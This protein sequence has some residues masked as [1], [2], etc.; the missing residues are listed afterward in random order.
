MDRRADLV[1]PLGYPGGPCYVVKRIDHSIRNLRIKDRLIDKIEDG[2]KLTNSEAAAVYHAEMEPGQGR[3]RFLITPHAQFRMD[4]RQITVPE[5]RLGLQRMLKQ[6]NDWKS[7][8]D[9]RGEALSREMRSDGETEWLDT[10]QGLFMAWAFAGKYTARLITTYWKG[11][12]DPPAP[13]HCILASIPVG[14]DEDARE[15]YERNIQHQRQRRQKGTDRIQRHRRYLKNKTN[16]KRQQKTYRM[17][18]KRHLQRTRKLLKNKDRT[19][20]RAGVAIPF[21]VGQDLDHVGHVTGYDP[22]TGKLSWEVGGRTGSHDWVAVCNRVTFLAESD[23]DDVFSM[24]EA[25]DS[26]AENAR[27][28]AKFVQ[29]LT[30]LAPNVESK[31]RGLQTKLIRVDKRNMQWSF[32]VSGGKDAHTV[33]LKAVPKRGNVS[34]LGASD[35]LMKCDCNFWRWQGPEHWASVGGYLLGKPVGTASKPMVK[36]PAGGHR[37]CKHVAAVVATAQDY[38]LPKMRG[39][40][41]MA[42]TYIEDRADLFDLMRRD[43]WGVRDPD[44]GDSYATSPDG[45]IRLYFKSQGVY[46]AVDNTGRSRFNPSAARSVA[47]DFSRTNHKRFL[48]MVYEMAAPER[49]ASIGKVAQRYLQGETTDA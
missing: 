22:D 15:G 1:P 2:G 18:N 25:A 27:T 31:S 41:A 34:K 48:D 9:P 24:I 33:R 19:R 4:Q 11:V 6:H 3:W 20:R 39:K 14:D 38:F 12:S 7:Q 32:A 16:V 36:D 47:M 40:L 30:G 26:L 37:V 49:Q 46:M 28:A 10:K 13:G 5:V 23:V 29:I 43:D 44:M 21:V 45:R 8:Q 17:R 35:V 42:K